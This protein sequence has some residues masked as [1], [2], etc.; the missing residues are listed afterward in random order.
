MKT[1]EVESLYKAVSD[2]NI[3]LKHLSVDDYMRS[4]KLTKRMSE[5]LQERTDDIQALIKEYNKEFEAFAKSAEVRDIAKKDKESL[6]PEEQEILS[7]KAPVQ[8]LPQGLLQGPEDF[9]DKV[10]AIHDREFKTKKDELN[11]IKDSKV[12]K[13]VIENTTPSNQVV[14]YEFLFKQ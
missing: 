5:F 8:V 12:F 13:A 6:T 7:R 14:L 9:I 2:S 4:I 10:N 11:F 1:Q 3:Q